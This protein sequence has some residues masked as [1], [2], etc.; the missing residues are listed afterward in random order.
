MRPNHF[1]SGA[2]A[3]GLDHGGFVAVGKLGTQ[4]AVGPD[5]AGQQGSVGALE[6]ELL[7][8][9]GAIGEGEDLIEAKPAR[10]FQGVTG[11]LA[12]DAAMLV[13]RVH[14]QGADL[15]QVLPADLQGAAADDL[16]ALF[17]HRHDKVAHVIV[18][19]AQG[20]GEQLA[21]LGV[22][23]QQGVD[24]PDILCGGGTDHGQGF[25]EAANK[26]QAFGLT[27]RGGNAGIKEVGEIG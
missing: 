2:P 24:R 26:K 15:G 14:R 12:A 27:R 1:C 18:E 5:L 10:L 19:L 25:S 16:A 3:E 21:A 17:V 6:A 9:P 13:A 22:D 7:E 23:L 8:E 20:T 4:D 11:Q